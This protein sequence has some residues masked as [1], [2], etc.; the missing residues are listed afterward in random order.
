[1]RGSLSYISTR[2]EKS[3]EKSADD[4]TDNNVCKNTFL[5]MFKANDLSVERFNIIKI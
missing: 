4:A 1:M 2:Y 3:N 5:G